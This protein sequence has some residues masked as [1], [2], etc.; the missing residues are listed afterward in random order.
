MNEIMYYNNERGV[1]M[2]NDLL[3]TII[4]DS[5]NEALKENPVLEEITGN[6][7]H[8]LSIID[9][10][11]DEEEFLEIAN[12]HVYNITHVHDEIKDKFLIKNAADDNLSYINNHGEGFP[13]IF[14]T[15]EDAKAFLNDMG[16]MIT[17][18]NNITK[19]NTSVF[20][21]GAITLKLIG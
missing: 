10:D 19:T 16:V 5:Y 11:D 3:R 9:D 17:S 20:N 15:E 18:I 2:Y 13:I 21:N 1:N 12:G 14:D 6:L 8:A 7:A 4:Q